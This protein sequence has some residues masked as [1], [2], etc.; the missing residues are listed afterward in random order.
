VTLKF[1]SVLLLR[2]LCSLVDGYSDINA[3][4]LVSL[5]RP[6]SS[7]GARCTMMASYGP[8][9]GLLTSPYVCE[10]NESQIHVGK[11]TPSPRIDARVFAQ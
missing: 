9:Q 8:L 4:P 7:D 1:L 2:L 11:T 6:G 5:P 10:Q 3:T